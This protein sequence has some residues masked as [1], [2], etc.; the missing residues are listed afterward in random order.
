MCYLSGTNWDF[1]SPKATFFIVTAVKTSNPTQKTKHYSDSVLHGISNFLILATD[2]L[3]LQTL[4]SIQVW[5][6]QFWR[7]H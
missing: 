7:R 4:A 3:C 1:I 2:D 5:Y 6:S